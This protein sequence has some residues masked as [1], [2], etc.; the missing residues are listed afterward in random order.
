MCGHSSKA[1][2]NAREMILAIIPL[3]MATLRPLS[4][5]SRLLT[6]RLNIQ[7]VNHGDAFFALARRAAIER[8][9]AASHGGWGRGEAGRPFLRLSRRSVTY[10]VSQG[11]NSL[12]RASN[13]SGFILQCSC[14]AFRV[15]ARSGRSNEACEPAHHA[16]R[17]RSLGL[18]CF[19]L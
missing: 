9:C 1:S 2:G 10:T 8:R 17:R 18:V 4:S 7:S 16:K 13:L 6:S 19:I 15:S 11:A 14:A 3:S 5:I 12:Q